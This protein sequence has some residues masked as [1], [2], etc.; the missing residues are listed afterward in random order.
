MAG[1]IEPQNENANLTFG[2]VP[3]PNRMRRLSTGERLVLL[4][5]IGAAGLLP[6]LLSHMWFP[7]LSGNNDEPVYLYQAD[8][9]RHGR[10]TLPLGDYADAFRPWLA[11]EDHGRV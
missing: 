6:V 1:D 11:G 7:L 2:A 9:A 10:F 4:V 8:L 5:I 3:P